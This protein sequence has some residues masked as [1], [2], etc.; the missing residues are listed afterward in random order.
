[1][2]RYL[3]RWDQT[4]NLI[5]ASDVVDAAIW[6]GDYAS[7]VP[8]S[9]SIVRHEYAQ[10][11]L[12]KAALQI[13]GRTSDRPKSLLSP[14]DEWDDEALVPAIAKL[15][16]RLALMPRDAITALEIARLQ[17]QVGQRKSAVR[18]IERALAAAPNDR[19]VLRSAA[20]F[21]S[22]KSVRDHAGLI[23][24]A[25][26]SSDV[27]R[28]DPWVQ[29]AEIA[30]ANICGRSP[31]WA[32]RARKI[33]DHSIRNPMSISE[34]ASGLAVLEF[35][36]GSPKRKVNRLL[37][38]SL[39]APTENSLAQAISSK[40]EIG[41][42]LDLSAHLLSIDNAFEARARAAYERQDYATAVDES[43]E[44]LQDQHLSPTAAM[45]GSF[46]SAVLLADYKKSLLFADH[47]LKADPN[48][49]S[50]LNTKLVALAFTGRANE[51]EKLLSR[52]Q[53]FE[54][55]VRFR[56]F[57]LAAR[58]LI[59]F[60]QG[61][62]VQGREWYSRTVQAARDSEQL[63]LVP[64]AIMYWI[65]Q[66][67][68]AGTAGATE[69]R[70]V[71]DKLDQTYSLKGYSGEKAATWKA[72]R[73]I[74]INLIKVSEMKQEILNKY[75]RSTAVTEANNWASLLYLNEP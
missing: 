18:Y 38:I 17:S 72:R 1:M 75:S 25:I 63:T 48:H 11:A 62:F 19:Y 31:K 51:A 2:Q 15:K 64:N 14:V 8:A 56:P 22:H 54:S 55:N 47:G 33:L 41:F 6:S 26:T 74:L 66:E 21:F 16:R 3:K 69:A 40:K 59:A 10:P 61:A 50:L 53:P 4:K 65:E 73:K 57:V 39:K 34:L 7:A 5:E 12:K 35:G 37:R 44:W 42:D 49:P 68:M 32:L 27:V 70:I 28:L 23:F 60:R 30:V 29:A 43:W 36:A 45:Y 46:I 52:L 20:N 13:L 71:V 58:G 24:E 9:L 67:L